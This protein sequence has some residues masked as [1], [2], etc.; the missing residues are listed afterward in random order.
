MQRPPDRSIQYLTRCTDRQAGVH[1]TVQYPLSDK[2]TCILYRIFC[3]FKFHP[4]FSKFH[5]GKFI[6]AL[7]RHLAYSPTLSFKFFV[8][9]YKVLN[10][11]P[12]KITKFDTL[13]SP[14]AGVMIGGSHA[15]PPL[16]YSGWW[17]YGNISREGHGIGS[18][19][20]RVSSR[21]R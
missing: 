5:M 8:R 13:T 3:T 21:P 10:H 12:F 11:R 4:N 15:S 20:H 9:V 16:I 1:C 17:Q 14:P 19:H 2:K 6:N 7:S 18:N